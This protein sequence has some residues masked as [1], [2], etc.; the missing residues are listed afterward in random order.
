MQ[1][2]QKQTKNKQ[3]PEQSLSP[4]SRLLFYTTHLGSFLWRLYADE[5]LWGLGLLPEPQQFENIMSHSPAKAI[6]SCSSNVIQNDTGNYLG[7]IRG[8]KIY[9]P[10]GARDVEEVYHNAH[11]SA[12]TSK[13]SQ[14]KKGTCCCSCLG[15]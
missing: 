7:Y 5:K 3:V 10:T 14:T 9:N 2:K 8:L 1:H 13:N 6:V 12:G 11:S 4:L 15:S